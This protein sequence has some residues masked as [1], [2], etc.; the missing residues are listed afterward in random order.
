IPDPTVLAQYERQPPDQRNTVGIGV[1]LPVPVANRNAGAIAAADVALSGA[2][3]EL[4]TARLRVRSELASTRDALD[5]AA[6][7]ATR[8]ANDLLP[9]AERVRSTVEYA[10]GQ[11]G[12]SLLELLEA[13]RNAN[14]IRLAAASAQGDVVATRADFAAARM[15]SLPGSRP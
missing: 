3:R 14:E 2:R 12:A 11:G 4:E 6:A 7:R 13:E 10:Y 9:K 15:T 5:A 8:Y 1:A